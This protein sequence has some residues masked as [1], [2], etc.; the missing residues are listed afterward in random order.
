MTV[1]KVLKQRRSNDVIA[2]RLSLDSEIPSG[3]MKRAV[4][5]QNQFPE[6][7]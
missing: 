4:I 1:Q 6:R 7:F 2:K 3:E 5:A